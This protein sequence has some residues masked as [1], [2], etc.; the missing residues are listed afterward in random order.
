MKK[1]TVAACAL[2]AVLSFAL[3]AGCGTGTNNL[4]GEETKSSVTELS[5]L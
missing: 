3:L 1:R 4:S 5:A 2:A